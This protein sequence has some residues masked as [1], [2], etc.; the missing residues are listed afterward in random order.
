MQPQNPTYSELQKSLT[1]ARQEISTLR[2]I[3]ESMCQNQAE[4]KS[5]I[6]NFP[7]CAMFLFDKDMIC[8]FYG[9]EAVNFITDEK[10]DIIGSKISD[11]Y[12]EEVTKTVEPMF[13][14]MLE[15][16][17]KVKCTFFYK[18]KAFEGYIA[19]SKMD[20]EKVSEW[21][22]FFLDQTDQKI[23]DERLRE[24]QR[25]ESLGRLAGGIAHDFN[26][27]LSIIFGNVQMAITMVDKDSKIYQYLSQIDMAAHHSA[28]ITKQLLG[29]ARKQTISP[30]VINLNQTIKQ[31]LAILQRLIGEHI[32]IKFIPS[33]ENCNIYI[34]P[35]QIDQIMLNLC[36]NARDSIKDTG[37]IIIETSFVKVN[38]DYCLS[39]PDAT[40]GN[41]VMLS[42][43][44]DGCGMDNGVLSNIFT[45]F[46]TTKDTGKGTGLG[47]SSVYGIVRQ[48]KGFINVYSEVNKGSTFKVYLP[49]HTVAP[50]NIKPSNN[51][52]VWQK[53][54]ETILLVEDENTLLQM[55]K[56]M[57]ETLG[58]KVLD[59]NT[60]NK[61]LEI[62]DS[63][64]GSIDL[65]ITDVVM[66]QMNGRELSKKI[67]VLQPKMK[68]LFVSGYT[69]NVIS[70]QGILDE[71]CNFL[72]KPFNIGFFSNKIREVLNG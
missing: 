59:A 61:A 5:M 22:A 55:M 20:D 43:S 41:Y 65:L 4:Y 21:V 49:V 50:D 44:D 33:K 54:N 19:P 67:S 48:N 72:Q 38:D 66:P 28:D 45:P 15:G 64:K 62:A 17:K 9:G 16:G 13:V 70:H 23:L 40:A 60:P 52:N 18:K 53:G 25:L 34:D 1:E 36:T 68:T 6:D 63:Y 24:T 42:I 8:K 29:F 56:T 46:F 27:M 71:G 39:R 11:I 35:L 14:E 37:N 47:L 32:S 26:N 3:N 58:Y 57:L 51:Q 12:P 31:R 69:T 7:K 10:S 2:K 30:K